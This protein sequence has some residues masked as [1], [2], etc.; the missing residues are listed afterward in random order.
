MK[1][2]LMRT[3]IESF[4]ALLK[5]C[6]NLLDVV[7]ILKALVVKKSNTVY[8]KD[9]NGNKVPIVINVENITYVIRLI[10]NLHL[11]GDYS[12][13]ERTIKIFINNYSETTSVDEILQHQKL[14][15]LRSLALLKKYGAYVCS[16]ND[17][18][19]L[20]VIYKNLRFIIRKNV[21]TDVTSGVLLSEIYEPYEYHNWFDKIVKAGDVFVDVGA[22][23]GGY[24]IRACK[25][26]VKVIAIE[27]DKDNFSLLLENL[28]INGC[29]N[30]HV[31][32]IAAGE[33]ESIKP[34]YSSDSP[35][36]YTLTKGRLT[37]DLV[38][39]K[40]LDNVLMNILGDK[41]IKLL[42]IDVEGAELRV[43]RGIH[44]TLKRTDYIMIEIFPQ[45]RSEVIWFL[46][47]HGFK[48]IDK[49]GLN[50]LFKSINS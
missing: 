32:N 15:W 19:R 23:I 3:E 16:L 12:F 40:P 14:L 21:Y 25:R 33:K 9:S 46:E 27:P 44:E 1:M 47:K 24:S 13:Q 31:L 37:R 41:R 35:D 7:K 43:L 2:I 34:L 29:R 36:T 6:N 39:V 22:Y 49:H 10:R 17:D 38:Y 4:L 20:V 11:L 5:I 45:N 18:H 30:V 28:R 48:L 42:K 26:G 50:N 8:I